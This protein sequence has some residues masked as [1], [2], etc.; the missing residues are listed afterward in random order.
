MISGCE[1]N[2][3]T[4]QDHVLLHLTV[5]TVELSILNY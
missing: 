5:G 3:N 4:C 2:Q 1:G